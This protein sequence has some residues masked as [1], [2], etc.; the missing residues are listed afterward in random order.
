VFSSASGFFSVAVGLS[1]LLGW[2][3]HIEFLKTWS[4]EPA[5]PAIV[6]VSTAICF[7]LIGVSLTLLRAAAQQSARA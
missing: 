1:A 3:F 4:A 7:L 5:E 2:A 6:K